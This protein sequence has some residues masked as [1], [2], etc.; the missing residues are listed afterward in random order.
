MFFCL[1]SKT[2]RTEST[3]IYGWVM[4]GWCDA[5]SILG[6]GKVRAPRLLGKCTVSWR[7]GGLA[8]SV[9]Q[10]GDGDGERW[11]LGAVVAFQREM[12]A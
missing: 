10:L 6:M 3:G 12:L 1:Y 7:G 4:S 11:G 2:T 8:S 5:A 9:A